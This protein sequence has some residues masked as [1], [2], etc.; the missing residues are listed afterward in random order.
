MEQWDKKF[1][2]VLL[3]LYA[4]FLF[5]GMFT[6]GWE[7]RAHWKLGHK[8]SKIKLYLDQTV[9]TVSPVAAARG[10]F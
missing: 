4:G 7:L 3:I 9:G 2:L 10:M 1:S 5:Q 6:A 8:S